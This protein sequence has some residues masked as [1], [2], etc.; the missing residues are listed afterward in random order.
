[1]DTLRADGFSRGTWWV[2][3]HDDLLRGLLQSSGWA[4]DGAHQSVG[5]SDDD[6]PIKLLRYHTALA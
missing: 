5:E 4:A 2:R 3:S 1:M 6:A